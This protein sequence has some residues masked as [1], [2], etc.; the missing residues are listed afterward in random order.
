MRKSIMIITAMLLGISSYAQQRLTLMHSKSLALENN[1]KTKNSALEID[2]AR[3]TKSEVYTK[4][5]P[6]IS[7]SATGMQA[8]DPL[9]KMQI[10]GG[11]LP[12]YDGNPANLPTANQF[13]YMP[14][15]ELGLFNQVG[16]GYLN[17]LQPVYA[18]GKIKNGNKLADLN[19]TVK[20]KQQKVVQNEI[21]LKTEREYWQIVALEEKQKSLDNYVKFLDTLYRQVSTAYQNGV[22]IRND[23]LKV[24]IKQSEL[25]VNQTQL[26]NGKKLALMQLCQTIGIPYDPTI[27]VENELDNF[28]DPQTYFVSNENVMS[29]RAEYQLL[30]NSV[31]ASHLLT[32][33]AKSEYMP[34]LGVG[35]SGYYMNQFEKGQNGAFNGMLYATV[36]IPISDWWGGKHKL[37]EM[38]IRENITINTLNDSKGLLNLQM[39]K[40]WTDLKETD[41]KITLIQETLEQANENLRVN[42]DSYRNGLIQLSDLLEARALKSDTEDKLTE[43]KT[44]YKTA[45]TNYLQVTGR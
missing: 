2:A 1:G 42:Q 35:L 13:A 16:L 19:L 37:N 8:I 30:E 10:Q 20:E 18:G 23:L 26:T 11:N 7:A 17:V 36:S 32:K 28:S 24:T 12:V 14:G 45:V 41:E 33:I 43:A 6:K 25:K 27:R 44:T 31:E 5:F 22:I 39:E 34:T 40:A 9:L 38:E 4:Y 29:T 3:E 15:T 21:L